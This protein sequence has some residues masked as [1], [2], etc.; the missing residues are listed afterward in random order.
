MFSQ[1]MFQKTVWNNKPAVIMNSAAVDSIN[2]DY[3]R[4]NSCLSDKGILDTTLEAVYAK[5]ERIK[6]DANYFKSNNVILN[7]QIKELKKQATI[8]NNIYET[9][10]IYYKEKAKGKFNAFLLGTG[11]GAIIAFIIQL[12]I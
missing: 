3:M 2:V 6:V 9:K 12:F 7:L 1:P 5:L 8:N 10:L 4:F 11:A